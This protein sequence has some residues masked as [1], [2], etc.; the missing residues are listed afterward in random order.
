M[1]ALACMRQ[2]SNSHGLLHAQAY[3]GGLAALHLRLLSLQTPGSCDISGIAGILRTGT[4]APPDCEATS[5]S[6]AAAPHSSVEA[7]GSQSQSDMI[8]ML[9]QRAVESSASEGG[10]PLPPS[11]GQLWSKIE[12]TK[13]AASSS[14]TLI[15]SS[16]AKQA[17]QPGMPGLGHA[18]A[19]DQEA[20]VEAI[21]GP[22]TSP[23][24]APAAGLFP[25]S[26]EGLLGMASGMLAQ[27][28]SSI[29]RVEALESRM[30]Q[31]LDMMER[32]CEGMGARFEAQL[33]R[34]EQ[35]QRMA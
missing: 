13:L 5:T 3:Q 7:E 10:Q 12:A 23:P 30:Q 21:A 17:L 8:R 25:G 27:L 33:Q 2:V 26:S 31:Q 6:A 32:M 29:G 14:F 24:Q 18:P 16:L 34:L 15:A 9:L 4:A 20:T 28:T 1:H 35:R 19:S 11:L 22:S